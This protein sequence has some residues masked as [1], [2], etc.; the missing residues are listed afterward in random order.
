M[1]Q[2]QGGRM[3]LMPGPVD[4]VRAQFQNIFAI[5]RPLLPPPTDAI[6]TGATYSG[7]SFLLLNELTS[8]AAED[9]TLPNGR[10]IRIYQPRESHGQ[11]PIGL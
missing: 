4:Q 2:M 8:S 1:E 7:L 10:S 5:I 6:K 11:L 9:S 3:T